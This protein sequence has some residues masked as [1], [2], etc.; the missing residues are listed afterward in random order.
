MPIK[1]LP[2]FSHDFT[3]GKT[4]TNKD[5][6]MSR[7]ILIEEQFP[8]KF[9]EEKEIYTSRDAIDFLSEIDESVGE[10]DVFVRCSANLFGVFSLLEMPFFTLSAFGAYVPQVEY[11]G[12]SRIEATDLVN[13]DKKRTFSREVEQAKLDYEKAAFEKYDSKSAIENEEE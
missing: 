9:S 2:W 10:E 5:S 3:H 6:I 1:L 8:Y 13:E 11:S 7:I 4:I 12:I